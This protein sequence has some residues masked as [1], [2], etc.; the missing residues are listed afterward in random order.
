[1]R[2]ANCDTRRCF[3]QPIRIPIQ[4][5]RIFWLRHNRIRADEPPQRAVAISRAIIHQPRASPEPVEASRLCPVNPKSVGT[6]PVAV[7]IL[8]NG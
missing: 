8:P 2:H 6:L 4:T 5:L 3:I 1:M 7:R